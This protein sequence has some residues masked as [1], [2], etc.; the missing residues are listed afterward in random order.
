MRKTLGKL[1]TV[2][3]QITE[4]SA[5]TKG[6]ALGLGM[7]GGAIVSILTILAEIIK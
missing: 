5:K 3:E 1:E 2:L 7:A 6:I 4:N